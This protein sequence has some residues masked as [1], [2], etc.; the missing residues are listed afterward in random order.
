MKESQHR[1][2]VGRSRAVQSDANDNGG[3]TLESYTAGRLVGR[4]FCPRTLTKENVAWSSYY[5]SRAH[6]LAAQTKGI[7]TVAN[8]QY[9]GRRVGVACFSRPGSRCIGDHGRL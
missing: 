9:F 7:P 5:S 6:D 1:R 8:V 2:P 3:I 4:V